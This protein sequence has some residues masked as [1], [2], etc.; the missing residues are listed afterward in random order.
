MAMNRDI[1]K[2]A[3]YL[4]KGSNPK[5]L[6]ESVKDTAKAKNRYAIAK[7]I[8][9]KE[10]EKA[11]YWRLIDM[12]VAAEEIEGIPGV[13]ITESRDIFLQA[14]SV[15]STSRSSLPT[16][17]DKYV[18]SHGLSY[19]MEAFEKKQPRQVYYKDLQNGRRWTLEY[20]IVCS[21]GIEFY[22]VNHSN[23]GGGSYGYGLSKDFDDYGLGED[24]T[25]NYCLEKLKEIL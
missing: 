9:W 13:D 10:A 19:T 11:F 17:L 16:I 24:N 8:G 6:A 12:G 25:L 18:R 15:G 22:F 21:N 23:E 4:K 7:A 5:V 2:M 20:H 14:A 3:E 1:Q